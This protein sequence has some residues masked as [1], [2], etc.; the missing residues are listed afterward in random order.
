MLFL[1]DHPGLPVIRDMYHP[2]S[3]LQAHE[4][5]RKRAKSLAAR[6]LQSVKD[7]KYAGLSLSTEILPSY[8]KPETS[9]DLQWNVSFTATTCDKA[10][11]FVAD[12]HS[13][14]FQLERVPQDVSVWNI[15]TC[16]ESLEGFVCMRSFKPVWNGKSFMRTVQVCYSSETNLLKAMD[17]LKDKKIDNHVYQPVRVAPCGQF[18][19]HLTPPCMS[20]TGQLENDLAFSKKIIARL[21]SFTGVQTSSELLSNTWSKGDSTLQLDIQ[22]MY[23]RTVHHYCYY[24]SLWCEDEWELVDRAG[25]AFLR[26]HGMSGLDSERF[27]MLSHECTSKQFLSTSENFLRPTLQCTSEEP[28]QSQ[29]DE[30]CRQCSVKASDKRYSCCLCKKQFSSFA[31]IKEHMCQRHK[32]LFTKLQE[33]I[34]DALV[35]EAYLADDNRPMPTASV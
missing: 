21:D 32:E 18:V 4:F 11:H 29:W 16:L 14:T 31:F 15:Y 33:H 19:V 7:G 17:A 28:L 35:M 5:R 12:P 27:W 30:L 6:F 24:S 3:K 26:S 2:E 10:P 13:R 25:A 34:H 9:N 20:E 22:I 23:L 1:K 8:I